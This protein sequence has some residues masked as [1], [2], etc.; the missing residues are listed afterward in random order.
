MVVR[1]IL[2][3]A[4]I[5]AVVLADRSPGALGQEGSPTIPMRAP[6]P[7][8]LQPQVLCRDGR[9]HRLTSISVLLDATAKLY[10]GFSQQE[11]TQNGAAENQL[12]RTPHPRVQGL[13]HFN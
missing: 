11:V 12:A 10:S 9:G 2:P 3:R 7:R 8:F 1:E 6:L 13:L 4:P 5:G